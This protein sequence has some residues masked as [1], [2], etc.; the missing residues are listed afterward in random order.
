VFAC[1]NYAFH[2]PPKKRLEV[3]LCL[4]PAILKYLHDKLSN[5]TVET[6]S[7][8]SSCSVEEAE[9][10]FERAVESS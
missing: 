7:G 10:R 6:S 4:F 9:E 1:F 8:L 3:L 5:K 2:F